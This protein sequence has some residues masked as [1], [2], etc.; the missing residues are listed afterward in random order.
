MKKRSYKIALLTGVCIILFSGFV[1]VKR[2]AFFD[3]AKNIDI[4]TRVFK[5]ITFGYVEGV[6]PEEFMRAGIRGMLNTLD[7]YTVFIDEKRQ[8]DIDLL[9]NGKYGGIGVTIGIRDNNVT[10][11][12]IL[13]GYSAQKQGLQVGDNLIE[14]NGVIITPK[15][16]DDIS[17]LVKGDPGTFV[18]LKILRP[19]VKDPISFELLREEIKLKN[20]AFAGFYPENSGFAYIKL[21]SFNRSAGEELKNT[22]QELKRQKNIEGVVLDLR[23]NPGGLLDVAVDI[24]NKFLGK[25]ELVVS[26]RGRDSLSLKQYNG[27]QEPMLKDAKLVVL[28]NDGSA[29]ASEIVAGAIQDHDRGV[30]LGTKSF[31]KGLVQTIVPLSYNTSLKLTT[32]KYFTPSGR[33]IQKINYSKD[34]KVFAEVDSLATT[35]FYTDNKRTVYSSGGITPDSTVIEPDYSEIIKDMLAKG[36]FFKFVNSLIEK[37][38]KTNL[39]KLSE[40]ELFAKFHEFCKNEN[41]SFASEMSKKV[42]ELASLSVKEKKY[43]TFASTFENIKTQLASRLPQEISEAKPE[44]LLEIKIE[45]ASRFRGNEGRI[46]TS[47]Q[48][49][50]QFSAAL[51]ILHNDSVYKYL[52]R[53]K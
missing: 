44:I 19:G 2:D 42:D 4:F 26:T 23:N 29:S 50:P 52:L 41:Y 15:N 45:I 7:P 21:T 51:K 22:L 34:N 9:T 16:I 53:K 5:E 37:T 30:I 17:S 28:V 10:I 35:A 24:A 43:S 38:E 12:E 46:K 39:E 11:V 13:D 8:E 36:I 1:T 49:D 27:L 20:I 48:D 18:R 31:G 3:I 32:A 40:S 25:G 6:N 47:L 14:V 33:C